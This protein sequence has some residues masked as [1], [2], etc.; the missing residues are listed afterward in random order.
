MSYQIQKF[1]KSFECFAIWENGFS[2]DE[3]EKILFLENLQSFQKG[4][5][6]DHGAPTSNTV[7]DS[8]IS[9]INPDNNSEW[10]FSRLT[11]I[12]SKINYDHFMYD[13]DRIE[14][15]QYTKYK[16]DQHYT[17]HWDASFEWRQYVRKIS[18][19]M[20]LTDPEEYEGGELE[21][22]NTGNFEKTQKLKPKRGDIV[23]FSSWMPHKV[24]PVI[25]GERKTLVSWVMGK[26][27]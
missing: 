4:T 21:V 12:T 14:S 7:R 13:I 16:H 8:D 23:F 20:M 11:S 27:E 18:M 19:V 2:E 15:I 10:L 26:R 17:W 1:I 25:S 6:G 22:C 24:H 3:L 9:W 5:V